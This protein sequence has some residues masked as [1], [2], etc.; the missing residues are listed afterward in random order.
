M[1]RA[2]FNATPRGS[3]RGSIPP[4]S[5]S[6]RSDPGSRPPNAMPGALGLPNARPSGPNFG[7]SG[8]G[9]PNNTGQQGFGNVTPAFGIRGNQENFMSS[10]NRTVRMR[11]NLA[12]MQKR[13]N[14]GAEPSRERQ[15]LASMNNVGNVRGDSGGGCGLKPGGAGGVNLRSTCSQAMALVISGS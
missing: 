4:T 6:R 11:D 7:V 15:P 12:Q 2:P 8:Y 9:G 14:A 5:G 13:M 1:N 3:T 10:V